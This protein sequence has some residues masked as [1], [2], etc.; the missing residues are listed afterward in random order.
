[1][2][3]AQMNLLFCVAVLLHD[4][5]FFMDQI[6][7]RSIRKKDV[8]E[9]TRKMEVSEDPELEALGDEERHGVKLDVQLRDRKIYNEKVLHAKGNDKHPITRAE[10]L[11]KFRLLASRVLSPS[12]IDKLQ[13]TL[14]NL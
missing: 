7:E 13:K 14:L 12:R 4:R 2:T 9:T 11:Q 3:T 1:M 8:L 5:D 6:T 10:V